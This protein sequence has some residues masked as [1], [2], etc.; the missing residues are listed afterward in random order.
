MLRLLGLAFAGADLVFE[1]DAHGRIGFA[2]GAAE[3]LT[4]RAEKDLV[5]LSWTDILAADETELL[6][7]LQLGVVEGERQ[8]PL[9]V[10]LQPSETAKRK[11]RAM[12]S[13]FRLPNNDQRLSCALSLGPASMSEQRT[14]RW[15]L[16]E[17][18]SFASVAAAM[19]EEAQGAGLPVRVDLVELEGLGAKMKAM[20]PADAQAMRARLA[21]AF[22][23]EAY[24]GVGAAELSADRY[25]LVRNSGAPAE[26]V[27]ERLKR[28][29][30]TNISPVVAEL[31]LPSDPIGETAK[32][33]RYALD[34][35]IADGPTEAAKGFAASVRRTVED[36]ARFKAIL[37][38]RSFQ[39]AYQPIVRLSDGKLHHF[40]ALAR[41]DNQ[42]S[43]AE[44]IRLAEE[45][46]LIL[47]FDL[48][49]AACVS[50]VLTRHPDVRIAANV[51]GLSL[52]QPR[53]V[54]RLTDDLAPDSK[55]R[56]RML[57][58]VTETKQL[59][60]LDAAKAVIER[61]NLFGYVVCL[62]DFGAGAASLD[63]LRRLPVAHVKIDGRFIQKLHAN[64]RES[65]ILKHVVALCRELGIGTI[66]E[67]IETR[68]AGEIA[69]RLGV[70]LGQGWAYSEPLPEPVWAGAE[71]PVVTRRKGETV[72]W[73]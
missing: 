70:E 4:G 72:D 44:T 41:F 31:P 33:M 2:L 8:G 43:P 36:A 69:R 46:D 68:G 58:E 52:M 60:D 66:A 25:A 57:L 15:G 26:R 11:R 13:V 65:V 53:F 38:E 59:G 45:L 28:A 30:G 63:Y 51:S 20:A 54:A 32:A 71:A 1:V 47:D 12:L 42:V 21:A 64:S 37:A 48:A 14:D 39:L 23:A 27:A 9:R 3:R 5:G 24:Q 40:E 22:R 6:N 10:G 29:A 61:L 16:M 73:S 17:A 56:G 67:M 19:I 50:E 18:A 34:R 7:A 55:S 35:F 62:D 49:V